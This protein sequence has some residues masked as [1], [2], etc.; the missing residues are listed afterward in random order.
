MEAPLAE[1]GARVPVFQLEQHYEDTTYSK[2]GRL[3]GF[4]AWFAWLAV[5][6]VFL[7]GFRNKLA[8]LV[9][10]TYSYFTYRLGARIITGWPDP[11]ARQRETMR[12]P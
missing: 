11:A 12:P 7:I 8:V 1:W 9:S 2:A 3:A 10:W 5:H 4:P 6:L